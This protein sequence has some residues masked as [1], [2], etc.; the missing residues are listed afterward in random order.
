MR[1]GIPRNEGSGTCSMRQFEIKVYFEV[2]NSCN[3]ISY[4]IAIM[5]FYLPDPFLGMTVLKEQETLH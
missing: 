5:T 2:T 4:I 3:I 1:T